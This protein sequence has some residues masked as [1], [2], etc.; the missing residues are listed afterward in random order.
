MREINPKPE[1][2]FETVSEVPG[3]LKEGIRR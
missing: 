3:T 2:T 1:R